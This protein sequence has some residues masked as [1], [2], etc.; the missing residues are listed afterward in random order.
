MAENGEAMRLK[1]IR[2][3]NPNCFMNQEL[4]KRI[5]HNRGRASNNMKQE[6]N[7]FSFNPM[8]TFP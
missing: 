8:F 1:A 6:Q 7:G 4:N 5:R 2:T 3:F